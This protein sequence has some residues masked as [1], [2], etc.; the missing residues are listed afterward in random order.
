MNVTGSVRNLI[1]TQLDSSQPK[2]PCA[3]NDIE[4]IACGHMILTLSAGG[5]RD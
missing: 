2:N 4:D 1:L 5:R 3:S